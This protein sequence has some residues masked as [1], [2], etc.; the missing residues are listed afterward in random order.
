MLMMTIV[1]VSDLDRSLHFYEKLGFTL[2]RK[3]RN[4]HWA[5]MLLGDAKLGLHLLDTLPETRK[6]QRVDLALESQESL[7]VVQE[8]LIAA[9]IPLERLVSDEAFG[10]SL[11]VRDPDGLHIQIN[12]H[13][14]ELYL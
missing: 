3:Q 13:D 1:Y 14:P 4:G 10:Y 11:I 5:E 12:Q 8:R 7:E 6:E 2:V 9:E